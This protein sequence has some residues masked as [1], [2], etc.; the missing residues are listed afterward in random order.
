MRLLNLLSKATNNKARNKQKSNSVLSCHLEFSLEEISYT[1]TQ[2][3]NRLVWFS[4]GFF[5]FNFKVSF[6]VFFYLLESRRLLPFSEWVYHFYIFCSDRC[7]WSAF[8][9]SFVC[10][11][12]PFLIFAI[13]YL[14]HPWCSGLFFL[15]FTVNSFT[16]WIEVFF[17]FE[18]TYCLCGFF[19]L[20][21]VD[22]SFSFRNTNSSILYTH[23]LFIILNT[24]SPTC[25]KSLCIFPL[26]CMFYT[27]CS[28]AVFFK[29]DYV[30]YYF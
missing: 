17:W 11:S 9:S 23:C 14:L 1:H 20:L 13:Q 19:F 27:I 15:Y 18:I 8:I 12:F 21:H 22:S 3:F 24:F 28:I 2:F 16:P 10:I 29:V 5:N 6:N 26:F 25:F 7:I 30:L 4:G